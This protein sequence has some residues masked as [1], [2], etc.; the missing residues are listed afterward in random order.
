MTGSPVWLASISRRSPLVAAKPISTQLWSP[1]TVAESER[2]LLRLLDGAGNPARERLFRMQITLCLHRALTPE[3]VA[4]LP[5]SF[6]A[7][8]AVD[9][10]GGPVAI[11]RETEPGLPSTQPCERPRRQSLD[12]SDPLLWL[13]LDCGACSPCRA[14]TALDEDRE[15]QTGLARGALDTLVREAGSR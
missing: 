2:L 15:R 6:H 14:R 5:D 11:L 12:P 9:L 4:Q 7:E 1:Q 10:A 13:P 3:E 8:P